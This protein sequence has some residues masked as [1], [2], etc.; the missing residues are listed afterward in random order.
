MAGLGAAIF[1]AVFPY[2]TRK[3]VAWFAK[4]LPAILRTRV[5]V[6]SGVVRETKPKAR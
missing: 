4:Y 2:K 5:A 1:V 6:G 3:V